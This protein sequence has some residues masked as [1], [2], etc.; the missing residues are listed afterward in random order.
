MG[1]KVIPDYPFGTDFT[2]DELVIARALVRLKGLLA[3][4]LALIGAL[5]GL[6]SSELTGKTIDHQ[7]YLARMGMT[8][9]HTLKDK[10]IRAGQ[11]LASTNWRELAL[12]DCFG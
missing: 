11:S 2:E 1:N 9:A 5:F 10:L 4:P 8:E 6:A 12:V 7:R 3:H